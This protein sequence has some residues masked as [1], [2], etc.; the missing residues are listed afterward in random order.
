LA[1]ADV[2]CEWVLCFVFFVFRI[3]FFVA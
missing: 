1:V 2:A 3:S